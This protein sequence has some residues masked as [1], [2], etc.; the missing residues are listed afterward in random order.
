MFHL[1]YFFPLS[2]GLP[3]TG[4]RGGGG[5]VRED[6]KPTNQTNSNTSTTVIHG[7]LN[8]A[9]DVKMWKFLLNE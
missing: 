1:F 8:T 9:V 6:M 4:G 7:V 2:I 5:G 3:F